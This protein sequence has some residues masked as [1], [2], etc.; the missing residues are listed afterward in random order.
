MISW[1]HLSK[2]HQPYLSGNGIPTSKLCP[3][4][5]WQTPIA[6]EKVLRY[7][8]ISAAGELIT[9]NLII[10]PAQ[11][12]KATYCRA[13]QNQPIMLGRPTLNFCAPSMVLI[14]IDLVRFRINICDSGLSKG[15][16][17]S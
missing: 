10:A 16:R 14:R 7:I 4:L 12:D 11:N 15:C 13:E 9:V 5:I 8:C 17:Y 3:P 6:I 1:C 2:W